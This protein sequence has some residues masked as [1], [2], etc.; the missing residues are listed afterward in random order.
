M[1]TETYRQKCVNK[2]MQAKYVAKVSRPTYSRKKLKR[3]YIRN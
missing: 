3:E 2:N 1:Q